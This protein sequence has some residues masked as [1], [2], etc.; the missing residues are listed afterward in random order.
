[1]SNI[2]NQKI[3]D[4]I[5]ALSSSA[6]TP[7]GGSA[8]AV[9]TSISFSLVAMVAELTIG[10]GRYKKVE[11][12]MRKVLLESRGFSKKLLVL[13]DKDAEAFDGAIKAYK[14][15][16][17]QAIIKSLRKA[18]EVPALI[19]K[20]ARRAEVLGKLVARQGNKNAAS[21]AKS[22]IYLARAAQKM[23]D[24]NIKIN[25]TTLARLK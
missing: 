3:E 18:T 10:K 14:S 24:E 25:K 12:K 21:D 23:A 7:G 16:D 20:F 17:K 8:A 22:A 1:M 13:A 4:F 19:K 5:S 2:K 11:K 6:P 9:A 15:K